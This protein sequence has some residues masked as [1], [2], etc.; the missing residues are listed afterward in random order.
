MLGENLSLEYFSGSGFGVFDDNLG[1]GVEFPR[2]GPR[3]TCCN[4]YL[5]RA[6]NTC[7]Q[8]SGVETRPGPLQ[9][10]TVSIRQHVDDDAGLVACH[11]LGGR[12]CRFAQ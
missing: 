7:T 12:L 9:A 10:G 2:R 5:A 4:E 6:S 11:P 1:A 3:D 8:K